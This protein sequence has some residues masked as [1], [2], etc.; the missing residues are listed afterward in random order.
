MNE[1]AEAV[2]AMTGIEESSLLPFTTVPSVEGRPRDEAVEAL[3]RS[4][5]A[6]LLRLAYRIV[7]D[8]YA[9][10]DVVMEAFCSLYRHW[11]GMRRA[12]AP[13]PYLRSAVIL[14]SRTVIRQLVRDR[15][16]R[17]V[18]DVGRPDPSSE[19]AI[20]GREADSLAEAVRTLPD[21][22]REVIVCRYYLELS[23][24]ETA[25]LLGLSVGS[26]KRHAH[27]A[28]ETLSARLEGVR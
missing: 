26:V 24:A 10:E 3:F 22:Q 28:R 15:N 16:R 12:S 21:R 23:E 14:G 6:G 7:G 13:L 2:T 1:P 11:S 20:A 17:P 18:W 27:R 25:Q 8:R 9:A 4:E 19:T 5:Y